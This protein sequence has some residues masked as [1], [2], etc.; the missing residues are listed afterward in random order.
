MAQAFSTLIPNDKIRSRITELA[1]EIS[2]DY[3]SSTE[4]HPVLL[5]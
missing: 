4:E 5:L 2:A 3:S 1:A